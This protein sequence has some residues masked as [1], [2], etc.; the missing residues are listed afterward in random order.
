MNAH[1]QRTGAE[2]VPCPTCGAEQSRLITIVKDVSWW[3]CSVCDA[4]WPL[5]RLNDGQDGDP[6]GRLLA[7]EVAD[8]VPRDAAAARRAVRPGL[9]LVLPE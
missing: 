3:G 8:R 6:R 4:T 5:D 2:R 1:C 7:E 9:R